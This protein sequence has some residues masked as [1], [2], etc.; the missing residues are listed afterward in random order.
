M[1]AFKGG[2][3]LKTQRLKLCG[4]ENLDQALYTWFVQMRQQGVPVSGPVLREKALRYEREMD[5]KDFTASNGWFN[6]WK[7]SHDVAFKAKRSRAP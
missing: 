6:R 4:N 3:S 1:K 2:A 5:I 7:N